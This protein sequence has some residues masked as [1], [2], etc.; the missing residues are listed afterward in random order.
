MTY[1][2]YYNR[3]PDGN[4]YRNNLIYT[5]LI[6]ED[7]KTF[8]QWYHNDTA[9]HN[10]QNQ[11]VD[12]ELMNVKWEREVKYLTLMSKNFPGLVPNIIDIDYLNKKIYL[13]IDGP[14]L[15]QRTLDRNCTYSD[16]VPDWQDQMLLLFRAYRNLGIWKY[17]LHPSSYFVVN[18]RLKSINYFFTY[19]KGESNITV[20]DHLSHI[21]EGRLETMK[22]K[23]DAL[24]IDWDEPQTLE[25]MQILAV[26]SFS[27]MYPREFIERAKNVFISTKILDA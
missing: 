22:P 17:S 18:G 12:P 15:W 10:G 11:V 20:R 13:E 2:Y 7:Q 5:S 1:N 24:G 9:Y 3:M 21:S 16:I 19:Q 26:E 4:K 8:V 14:D 6:S 27:D 23:T 25:T